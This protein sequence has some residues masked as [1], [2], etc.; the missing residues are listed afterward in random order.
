MH[1]QVSA[2]LAFLIQLEL[3]ANHQ[4]EEKDTKGWPKKALIQSLIIIDKKN[5]NKAN[6]NINFQPDNNY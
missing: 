6:Q 4:K 2:K 3:F 1:V 5:L